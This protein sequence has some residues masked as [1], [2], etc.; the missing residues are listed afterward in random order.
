MG[1]FSIRPDNLR[2]CAARFQ[3][4]GERLNITSPQVDDVANELSGLSGMDGVITTV[5]YLAEMVREEGT[6]TD[7]LGTALSQIIQLYESHEEG[8]IENMQGSGSVSEV[9]TGG[10]ESGTTG[11][12]NDKIM[13]ISPA[14]KDK[15]I[16][17]YENEHPEIAAE[18][19][20]IFSNG[21]DLSVLSEDDIRNIK[22]MAYTAPEPDRTIFLGNLSSITVADWRDYKDDDFGNDTTT[23]TAFFSP[24]DKQIRF[25]DSI[26]L[27]GDK[28]GAYTTIFHESGHAI[29]DMINPAG[30]SDSDTFKYNSDALG[31]NTTIEDAI[32]YDVYDNLDNPHSVMS[33]VLDMNSKLPDDQKY[34][35]DEIEHVVSAM[36]EDGNLDGH[37]LTPRERV[38]YKQLGQDFVDGIP[39][40]DSPQYEAVTDVYGGASNNALRSGYSGDDPTRMY[41]GHSDDYWKTPHNTNKE[42]WAEYFSYKMAGDN[43]NLEKFKEYYPEAYK[44]MQEYEKYLYD[45]TTGA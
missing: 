23:P 9:T 28:K 2:D 32:N 29:D 35:M 19:D 42:L 24:D 25:N 12:T 30:G 37:G 34:G 21:E 3:N 11:R 31:R 41:Y 18:F 40:S 7:N 43:E 5:R 22:Y 1:Y 10:P 27:S 16:E 33:R 8:I 36:R 45:K 4:A 26:C 6:K 44:A 13:N 20:R 17:N 38:L 39:S 14:Y 15:V